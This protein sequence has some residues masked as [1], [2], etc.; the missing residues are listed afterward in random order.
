MAELY[1]C[2]RTCWHNKRY[3]KAHERYEAF[4]VGDAPCE[5][6]VPIDPPPPNDQRITKIISDLELEI[7]DMEKGDFYNGKR[8]PPHPA[9]VKQMAK[10][11]A[12]IETLKGNAPKKVKGGRE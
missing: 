4:M 9:T 2:L 8:L 1:Y 6:L 12:A 7:A 11:K 5:F 10:M 3:F